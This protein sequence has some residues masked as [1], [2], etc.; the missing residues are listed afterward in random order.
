MMN[1]Q[2]LGPEHPRLAK[3]LGNLARALAES[4]EPQAARP[5]LEESLAIFRKA[6]FSAPSEDTASILESLAHVERDLENLPKAESHLRELLAI[7]EKTLSADDPA[8]ARVRADLDDVLRRA[9][10]F[11]PR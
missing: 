11:A 1:R 4:G 3:V 6:A 8:T 9:T 5:L 10:E 7:R 2:L